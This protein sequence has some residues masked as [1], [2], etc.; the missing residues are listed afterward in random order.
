[1]QALMSSWCTN[2]WILLFSLSL[3]FGVAFYVAPVAMLL[4]TML[5]TEDRNSSRLYC[6]FRKLKVWKYACLACM[7]KNLD[8]SVNS[9][10]TAACISHIWIPLSI[11]G[12]RLKQWQEKHSEHLFTMK[13]WQDYNFALIIYIYLLIIF[14]FSLIFLMFFFIIIIGLLS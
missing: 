14:F 13:F 10:I 6:Y 11:S 2:A 9:Q 12:L 3:I 1:M 7:F 4:R 5:N 8:Q